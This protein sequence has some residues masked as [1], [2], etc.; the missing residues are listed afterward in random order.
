MASHTCQGAFDDFVQDVHAAQ[1]LRECRD[2][3]REVLDGRGAS[4]EAADTG[5]NK[6]LL[7]QRLFTMVAACGSAVPLPQT[8]PGY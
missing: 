5:I 1:P 8:L 4:T 3:G 6:A 2:T 7:L